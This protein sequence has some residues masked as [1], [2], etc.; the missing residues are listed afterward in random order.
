MTQSFASHDPTEIVRIEPKV[1]SFWR[2]F[3]MAMGVFW[4]FILLSSLFNLFDAGPSLEELGEM[5]L[6][7]VP[8]SAILALGLWLV[9]KLERH[10]HWCASPV[11]L[12]IYIRQKPLAKLAWRHIS[13]VRFTRQVFDG[14]IEVTL[15]GPER[16]T[17]K[18]EGVDESNFKIVEAFHRARGKRLKKSAP[19]ENLGKPPTTSHTIPHSPMDLA[20]VTM[21]DG[22]TR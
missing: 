20:R 8:A 1:L 18:I 3:W 7:S 21:Q 10:R 4:S 15:H 14:E 2:A 13:K 22:N 9:R 16:F 11:R 12:R 19:V 5:C 17:F 6:I